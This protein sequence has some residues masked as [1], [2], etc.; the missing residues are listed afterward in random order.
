LESIPLVSIGVTIMDKLFVGGAVAFGIALVLLAAVYWMVP[1]GS[2]PP[3]APGFLEGSTHIHIKHA[4]F[5]LALGLAL[6]AVAWVK[7]GA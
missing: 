1:A 4:F 5:A 2:L 7:R 6:F 3:Y